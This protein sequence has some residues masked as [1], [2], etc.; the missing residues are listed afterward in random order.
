MR[1]LLTVC[2]RHELEGCLEKM[3]ERT[4]ILRYIL[5]VFPFSKSKHNF[6]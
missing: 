2:Q 3:K 5:E 4:S 1:K 6:K